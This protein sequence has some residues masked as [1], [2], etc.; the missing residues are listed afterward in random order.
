M[1][2][3]YVLKEMIE[4]IHKET[5]YIDRD[6]GISVHANLGMFVLVL[7]THGDYGTIAFKDGNGIEQI[8]LVDLYKLLSP[9]NFPAMKGK[10]KM[11][12][13]QACSGGL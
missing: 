9:E 5:Q 13:M 7:M 8:K 12:I 11:I 4:T 10:P 2:R 3:F 1:L 6:T